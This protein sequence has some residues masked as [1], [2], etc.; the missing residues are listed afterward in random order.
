M[1]SALVSLPEGWGELLDERNDWC[2]PGSP[3]AAE[4]AKYPFHEAVKSAYVTAE[5][6]ILA[7]G[8]HLVALK[9][10]LTE[11]VLTFAPW[12]TARPILSNAARASWLAD[13]K[14]EAEERIARGLS[15][16]L[17][18]VRSQTSTIPAFEQVGAR[19]P[20]PKELRE[21]LVRRV[22]ALEEEAR[23]LGIE[24]KR[25]TSEKLLGFGNGLP[26]DTALAKEQFGDEGLYRRLSSAVHGQFWSYLLG[27]LE[28]VPGKLAVRQTFSAE[29]FVALV[30]FSIGWFSRPAWAFARQCGLP[31]RSFARL[32][33]AV[34][35]DA[36]LKSIR[37][38]RFWRADVPA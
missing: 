37:D 10:V 28:R 21:D 18:N 24:E 38:V 2:A 17:S 23:D 6:S 20:R 25:S 35:D 14:I 22:G 12:T 34:Y 9:R 16:R 33:E 36:G 30:M 4:A 26:S 19:D 29:N 32:L 1:L 27:S 5:I 11:P 13:P 8:D 7:A 31:L 15:I 3:A